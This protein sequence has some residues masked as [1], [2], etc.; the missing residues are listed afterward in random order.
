MVDRYSIFGP[1][2]LLFTRLDETRSYGAILN[3][4]VRTGL[5]VSFLGTGPRVPDDV[6]PATQD[7][8]VDF[9]LEGREIRA[10]AAA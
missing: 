2:K 6:E 5:P 1:A 10:V 8:I 4:S 3:E 9:L 7:R